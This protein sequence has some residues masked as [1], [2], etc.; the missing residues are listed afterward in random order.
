MGSLRQ[1]KSYKITKNFAIFVSGLDRAFS[2]YAN[3][4]IPILSKEL[5]ERT[6][7]QVILKFFKKVL[8]FLISSFYFSIINEEEMYFAKR[9]NQ[10]QNQ[11]QSQQVPLV[12]VYFFQSESIIG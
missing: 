5:I 10:Q 12:A 2:F 7:C 1:Q 11:Q 6:A 8:A 3:F 4:I 9:N